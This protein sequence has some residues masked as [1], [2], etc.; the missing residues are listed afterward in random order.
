MDILICKSWPGF[1]GSGQSSSP[2]VL[3]NT[4]KNLFTNLQFFLNLTQATIASFQ[5]SR[6]KTENHTIAV[7]LII[8]QKLLSL[9]YIISGIKRES[10]IHFWQRS[11]MYV[12]DIHMYMYASLCL[13]T[14]AFLY[15]KIRVFGGTMQVC[16]K[17][18]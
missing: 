11:H 18:I 4:S 17:H 3:T 14:P 1:L 5:V 9:K 10:W 2:L 16:Y 7:V 13:T 8:F 12:C 6:N 15:L